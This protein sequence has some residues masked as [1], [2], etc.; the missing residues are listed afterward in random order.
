MFD[1]GFME[2]MLIGVVALVVIG[3]DKLPGLTRTAGMWVGK[4]RRTLGD[5]KSE[6]EQE[7]KTEELNKMLADQKEKLNESMQSAH[8][9]VEETHE[10]Y[11]AIES[12]KKKTDD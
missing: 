6:I 1:V 7:L 3:P 11:D 12:H 8:H 4:A 2:M 5:V 10:D 9:I